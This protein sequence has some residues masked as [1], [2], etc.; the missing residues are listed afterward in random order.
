MSS[1][2]RRWVAWTVGGEM[3]GFVAPATVGVLTADSPARVA[4]PSL[5]AAGAVE[6]LLLGAA[7]ARALAPAMPGLRARRFAGLTGA[8]AALAYL[9]GMLPSSV[10]ES[11][12]HAPPALLAV[13]AT[14]G[15][16][17]LLCSLGTAQWLELRRHVDQSW[18]WIPLTAGAWLVGLATFMLIATP[19]WRP[20]QTV[21]L[22]VAIGL[23]AALAMATV[24][25]VL[26]GRAVQ[27]LADR[28]AGSGQ[29]RDGLS[30]RGL[31]EGPTGGMPGRAGSRRHRPT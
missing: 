30:G 29:R 8:A 1:L 13:G 17:L 2:F 5:V 23:V 18:T 20:G 9:V 12:S 27:R 28:A 16:L 24:V 14:V 26:T 19:L 4:L 22:S 10:G 11:L 25:A 6:G 7:Q 3:A 31:E 21:A 15:G